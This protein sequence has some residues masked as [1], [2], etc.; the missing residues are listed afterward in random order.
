MYTKHFY[1]RM[2][3]RVHENNGK[4][5]NHKNQKIQNHHSKYLLKKAIKHKV[6]EYKDLYNIKYIYTYINDLCYKYVFN[7][8]KVITVYEVN[9]EKEAEKYDLKFC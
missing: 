8:Q 9:L 2:D 6:A 4:K 7:G 3:E 5:L 1:K